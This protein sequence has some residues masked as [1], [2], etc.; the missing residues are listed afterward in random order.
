M[1]HLSLGQQCG[2]LREA[3][4]ESYLSSKEPRKVEPSLVHF[5]ATIDVGTKQCHGYIA[6]LRKA[7]PTQDV[8][9][10][11]PDCVAAHANP[12]SVKVNGVAAQSIEANKITPHLT[13]IKLPRNNV[14]SEQ[15]LPCP[16]TP[17]ETIIPEDSAC[18]VIEATSKGLTA[19]RAEFFEDCD[20]S[21]LEGDKDAFVMTC[22]KDRK[23]DTV[24]N[25]SSAIICQENGKWYLTHVKHQEMDDFALYINVG[26]AMSDPRL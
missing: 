8:V 26:Y 10:T 24:A 13:L 22:V 19:K 11:A 16:Y 1:Y 6:G 21:F 7:V 25:S 3:S 17:G 2:L 15:Q 12:A 5:H 18:L 23:A 14:L 4:L 20:D 9:L